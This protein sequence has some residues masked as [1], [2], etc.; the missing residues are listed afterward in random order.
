[1]WGRMEKAQTTFVLALALSIMLVSSLSPSL[2]NVSAAAQSGAVIDLY[3]EKEPFDGR[4]ANQSSDA[5]EPQELVVLHALA[6]YNDYPESNKLVAFLVVGPP[7]QFQ[8]VTIVGSGRTDENGM[9]E[10]SFRL[11]WPSTHAEDITFGEWSVIATVD[12]AEE[13]ATDTLSFRV[14]WIIRITEIATLNSQLEPQTVYARQDAMIFNLTVENIARTAKSATIQIDVQ[15]SKQQPII[16]LQLEDILFEPGSNNVKARSQIPIFANNGLANVSAAPF[17]AP[18]ESGGRLYSP[19][20][21]TTFQITAKDIAITDIR[22]SSNVIFVGET[23]IINVTVV[24]KG[25]E[26]AT[27]DLSTYYNSSVIETRQAVELAPSALETFS[28]TWNTSSVSP[29]LYRIS[30]DAPLPGDATPWDNS[31]VDG[32]VEIK[33][34]VPSERIHDVAVL[35]VVPWPTVVSLGEIVNIN[36]TFKNK[37]TETESDYITV[38]YDGVPIEKKY[39]ANL[40]PST[41]IQIPFK[42]NTSGVFP[43]KYV[44]SAVADT[45]PGETYVADNT[46][47]DGT[48]T[49]LPYPPYF[50]TLNWLVFLIIVILGVIAGLILLFLIL[51][52]DRI[53]RRKRPRPSYT[54]I[55]H[56]HI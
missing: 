26:S 55:V 23:L 32:I 13:V 7:N 45:V 19:A 4:G 14:G 8:N 35:N 36:V 24:N 38:Y 46:F 28:F 20:I 48:V 34:A 27:F 50:P 10:F 37:G 56:P 33:T 22:L 1:M 12:I 2:R 16:H 3:T 9:A 41:E 51:A 31:L 40:P 47:V 17:T 43:M 21:Y 39:V 6:T 15:D 54:V 18:P 53:R 49:I 30:A 5:F 29:G 44:I 52:L 25:N 42:W 11:P